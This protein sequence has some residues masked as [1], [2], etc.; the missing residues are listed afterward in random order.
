MG[1][2]IKRVE[3][4]SGMLKNGGFMLRF[5][6]I[7][8]SIVNLVQKYFTLKIKIDKPKRLTHKNVQH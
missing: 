4:V 5:E 6:S 1:F 2:L 8:G 7:L 3:E